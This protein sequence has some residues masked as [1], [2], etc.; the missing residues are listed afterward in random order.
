MVSPTGVD[1]WNREGIRYRMPHAR[2]RLS[3]RW[4]R[5]LPQRRV[6]DIGC[7]GAA[8]RRLLSHDFTY[9]GC[10]ITGDAAAQLPAGHFLQCDFNHAQDLSFF[11]NQS[12]DV[13]HIGGLLEYLGEPGHLLA[14]A[15]TLVPSGSPLV[16]S[17]INF[18]AS[19]YKDATRHHPGWIYKP[20]FNDFVQGLHASGWHVEQVRPFLGRGEVKNAWFRLRGSLLRSDHPWIRRSALQFLFLARAI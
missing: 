3:A 12:I 13:I 15:R 16:V 17:M 11:F 8:L 5:R 19:Y 6:L 14:Q 10:D 1:Y 18:D 7:S 2:L 20:D 9:F 4:L